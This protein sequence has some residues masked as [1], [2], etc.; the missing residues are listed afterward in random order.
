MR[1]DGSEM[2]PT[3]GQLLL[4]PLLVELTRSQADLLAPRVDELRH[5]GLEC[6]P[7]GG[8]VFLL[9]AVPL[10]PGARQSPLALAQGLL[11]EAA[12]DADDW[13]DHVRIALA[14]HSAVRRGQVLTPAEQR[15]LLAN[16]RTVRASALCPH[17]SPLLL[18]YTA[19]AL[20][21]AFEW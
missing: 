15:A 14:C 7:F 5:M 16:L 1:D 21:R 6:Q 19:G 8:S 20:I 9:R 10:L 18:R 11:E 13:L 17:G 4:E 3:L 12:V 2:P